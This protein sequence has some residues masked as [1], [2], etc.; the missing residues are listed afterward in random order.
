MLYSKNQV[1]KRFITNTK[2]PKEIHLSKVYVKSEQSKNIY[3]KK[4]KYQVHPG[5]CH[6][7]SSLYDRELIVK[8]LNGL[9]YVYM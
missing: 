8:T 6:G 1:S 4:L 7:K 9:L 5:L 2:K 3:M